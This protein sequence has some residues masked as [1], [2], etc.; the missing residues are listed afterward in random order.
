MPSL[1]VNN[2]LSD[3]K[4][5]LCRMG[6]ASVFDSHYPALLAGVNFAGIESFPL[7]EVSQLHHRA[8]LDIDL[9]DQIQPLPLDKSRGRRSAS[10]V[11]LVTSPLMKVMLVRE[12]NQTNHAHYDHDSPNKK[13][14]SKPE[15][16]KTKTPAK[17]IHVSLEEDFLY[18]LLDNVSGLILAMGRYHA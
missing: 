6:L 12:G 2:S 5:L 18:L 9:E 16:S 14:K 17:R 10:R 11:S 3:M 1:R 8:V 7:P 13:E 4:S 15:I